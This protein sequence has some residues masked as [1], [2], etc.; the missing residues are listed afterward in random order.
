METDQSD[1]IPTTQADIEA[2]NDKQENIV[3]THV[4]IESDDDFIEQPTEKVI[5]KEP[6]ES[7]ENKLIGRSFSRHEESK[8]EQLALDAALAFIHD[9]LFQ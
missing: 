9:T 8:P 4:G 3:P 7:T 5:D 1:T 6:I 2:E